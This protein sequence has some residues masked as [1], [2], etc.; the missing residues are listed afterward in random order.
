MVQV[1][2]GINKGKVQRGIPARLVTILFSYNCV[3]FSRTQ[4]TRKGTWLSIS[5]S[6]CQPTAKLLTS[7]QSTTSSRTHALI[8]HRGVPVPKA[9]TLFCVL[10]P[11]PR[12][13]VRNHL[14]HPSSPT[15]CGTRWRWELRSY[16]MGFMRR[17]GRRGDVTRRHGTRLE[18]T[19]QCFGDR[20]KTETEVVAASTVC[21]QP[22][23]TRCER[24]KLIN[25]DTRDTTRCVDLIGGVGRLSGDNRTCDNRSGR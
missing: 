9:Y 16:T 18:P 1:L 12:E 24:C 10:N 15:H 8:T 25:T 14:G 19:L 20:W 17:D 6:H 3:L 21:F 23:K 4:G 2:N 13:Q 5:D 7:T 11:E 22:L